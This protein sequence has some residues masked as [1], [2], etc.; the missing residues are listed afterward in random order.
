MGHA[1]SKACPTFL[2]ARPKR[3]PCLTSSPPTREAHRGGA[4]APTAS[5]RAA[6]PQLRQ[7]RHAV[8][9]RE[10]VRRLEDVQEGRGPGDLNGDGIG[11]LLAQDKANNLYR[12]PGTGKGTFSARSKLLTNWSATYNAAVGVGDLN[13]DGKTDIVA[14][15]TGGNL[16]R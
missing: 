12:Y 9:P 2:R 5:T 8:G 15:D 1:G 4:S 14:R 6:W 13:R 10:V 16:Y 11:D 3:R 7:H